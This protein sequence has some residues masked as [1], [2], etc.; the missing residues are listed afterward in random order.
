[1]RYVAANC[2]E[3]ESHVS[4]QMKNGIPPSIAEKTIQRQG[5]EELRGVREIRGRDRES[6]ILNR[7]ANYLSIRALV[8]WCGVGHAKTE[9]KTGS[10]TVAV[11]LRFQALELRRQGTVRYLRTGR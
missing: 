8:V 1:M 9:A 7:A 6:G 5:G 4:E 11:R 3:Q 2:R 10:L